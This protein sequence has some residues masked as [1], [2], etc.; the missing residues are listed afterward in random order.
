MNP[1]DLIRNGIKSTN[2]LQRSVE[3]GKNLQEHS[4]SVD[5][6]IAEGAS[7]EE[8]EAAKM[9][10]TGIANARRRDDAARRERIKQHEEEQMREASYTDRQ[11]F[12]HVDE[13]PPPGSALEELARVNKESDHPSEDLQGEKPN[14]SERRL[15]KR[16]LADAMRKRRNEQ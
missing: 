12:G 11:E 16:M 3:E 5:E 9:E 4:K 1:E 14:R 7:P 2:R 13:G 15:V 8:I 6:L 10:Y